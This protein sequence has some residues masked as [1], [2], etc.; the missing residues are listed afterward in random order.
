DLDLVALSEAAAASARSIHDLDIG[1]A[2]PWE[3]ARVL[4]SSAPASL[5]VPSGRSARLEYREDGTVYAAVKLQELFGLA[6]TPRLGPG[7]QPLVIE[8]LAPNGRPVQTT[9]DLRSFWER[10]YPEVRKELRGRYPKHPWP[11]DPWTAT[12]THRT[13]RRA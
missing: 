6:E 11:E 13:T 12:P 5:P 8:L 7:Q 1:A 3:A 9:T 10:T 2:L 4:D